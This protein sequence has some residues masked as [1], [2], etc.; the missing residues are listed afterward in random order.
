[1]QSS[2]D[3]A[4]KAA[5][6]G[7]LPFRVYIPLD[8]SDVYSF[9][10]PSIELFTHCSILLLLPVFAYSYSLVFIS[11]ICF[12]LLLLLSRFLRILSVHINPI[13]LSYLPGF[14]IHLY[15]S[16]TS[17]IF[18]MYSYIPV[19][20]VWIFIEYES[21]LRM[22]EESLAVQKNEY[23]QR[24]TLLSKQIVDTNSIHADVKLK[25]VVF[26]IYIYIYI[27]MFMIL[28]IS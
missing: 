1:M 6:A 20:F 18:L 17:H 7:V 9:V 10:H 5:R 15:S 8:I 14:L 28:Y 26:D 16:S 13:Y 25:Y 22:L 4:V 12:L 24:I 3:S 11:L 2:V 19:C 27:P 21:R 23:E